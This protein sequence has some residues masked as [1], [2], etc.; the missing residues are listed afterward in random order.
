MLNREAREFNERQQRSNEYYDT[1]GRG[2]GRI[3]D[4]L[5][6]LNT[7][8]AILIAAVEKLVQIA[9]QS[10]RSSTDQRMGDR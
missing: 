8:F 10:R 1:A 9:V 7:N 2:L 5:R 6:R 4:E 3:E